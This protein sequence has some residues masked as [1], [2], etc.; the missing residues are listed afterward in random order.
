[1]KTPFRLLPTLAATCAM[2]IVPVH[3]S[4]FAA[5]EDA[6]KV[7]SETTAAS[8]QPQSSSGTESDVA[9]AS[10]DATSQNYLLRYKF[11]T[12][13]KLR[14][15]TTSVATVNGSRQEQVTS[16]QTEVQQRRVFTVDEVDDNGVTHIA[17]Q[18]EHIR[19]Q[20][21]SNGSKPIVFDSTMKPDEVPVMFRMTAD[22]LRGKATRFQVIATGEA[23][24]DAHLVLPASAEEPRDD[25]AAGTFLMPLPQE[26][27]SV[28]DSWTD[29]QKVRVR[30]T[31]KITREIEILRSFRLESVKDGVAQIK[32]ASS[33]LSPANSPSIRTQLIQA[34]PQGTLQFD[35]E[36]GIMVGKQWKFDQTVIN[37]AGQNSVVSS[38]GTYTESLIRDDE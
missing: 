32:F 12:G 31:D 22:R 24:P 20:W 13:Q 18:Y 19:M 37:G 34:T 29:V 8:I 33:V 2:V 28:G 1:M 4:A 6:D 38:F 21:Q 30:V 15:S 25:D 7:R 27:V 26:R 17:M 36:E 16:D 5:T 35:I 23:S 10:S 3:L 9:D 11:Q 14:Y